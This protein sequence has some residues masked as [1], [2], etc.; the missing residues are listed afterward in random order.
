MP[1]HKT[2]KV[3]KKRGKTAKKPVRTING[4]EVSENQFLRYG[5]KPNE[6]FVGFP[7]IDSSRR[8]RI[9]SAACSLSVFP[10]LTCPE[11]IVFKEFGFKDGERIPSKY[12]QIVR[13]EIAKV[14]MGQAPARLFL[15]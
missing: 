7:V 9:V 10:K 12:F 13:A 15:S 4:R 8:T 14:L 1:P 3:A 2:R 11:E 5:K 6:F